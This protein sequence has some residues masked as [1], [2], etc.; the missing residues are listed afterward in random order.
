[1]ALQTW[2]KVAGDKKKGKLY[3]AGNLAANYRKGVATTLKFTLN[4]GEGSSQQPVLTPEMG[5][6]IQRY[7]EQLAEFRQ[8]REVGNSSQQSS[9]PAPN[10]EP[11]P[12]YSEDGGEEEGE[13]M[14][15][16]S[17]DEE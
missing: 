12:S 17:D 13:D 7:E 8:A 14:D 16:D 6:L 10:V 5:E 2:T 1:L 4:H 3:G 9:V 15:S 11:F